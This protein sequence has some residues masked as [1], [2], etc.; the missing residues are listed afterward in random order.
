MG[1][2]AERTCQRNG[3]GRFR[4]IRAG[5]AFIPF[6]WNYRSDAGQHN[7]WIER[8]QSWYAREQHA[9]DDESK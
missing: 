8:K 3:A 4:N 7:T 6:D 2:G 1:V 5:V 9:F